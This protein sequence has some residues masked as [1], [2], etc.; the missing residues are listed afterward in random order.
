MSTTDSNPPARAGVPPRQHNLQTAVDAAVEALAHVSPEQLDFLGARP[1]GAATAWLV[2]VLDDTFHLD[3]AARDFRT[4]SG[5]ALAPAW[6]VVALHYLAVTAR[7]AP[8]TPEITFG[9]LPGG[10]TYASVYRQRVNGRLCATAGRDAAT[11][12][13]SALHLRAIPLALGHLGFEFALFP[14]LSVRLIWHAGDAEFGPSATILLPRTIEAFFCIED[15]VVLSE[16][17]VSRLSG[18]PYGPPLPTP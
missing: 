9:D 18:Q 8:C 2:P 13:A 3:L 11:L 10:L 1:A 14:R 12:K 16:R 17:L 7:P 4:L 15:I 5:L 6:Q